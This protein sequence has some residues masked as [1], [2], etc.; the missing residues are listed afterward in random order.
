MSEFLAVGGDP[1]RSLESVNV[2][3]YSIDSSGLIRWL[4]PAAERLLGDVR[5]R[6]YTRW[7]RQDRRR[8]LDIFASKVL[9]T[10]A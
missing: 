8:A 1:Q 10:A 7:S 3:S 9:G 2:P 4:N 5:G 6:H